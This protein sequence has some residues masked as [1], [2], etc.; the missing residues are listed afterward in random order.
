MYRDKSVGL[1]SRHA[2]ETRG[3]YSLAVH[4]VGRIARGERPGHAAGRLR[5][6]IRL[7][8]TRRPRLTYLSRRLSGLSHLPSSGSVSPTIESTL[9]ACHLILARFELLHSPAPQR[10]GFNCSEDHSLQKEADQNH[11][12]GFG[13]RRPA[14]GGPGRSSGPPSAAFHSQIEN[15]CGC[16]A[17][18]QRP[19]YRV[20][21]HGHEAENGPKIILAPA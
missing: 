8:R 5:G 12:Q 9:F 17:E 16:C 15:R 13:S 21:D 4:A 6:R 20:D 14:R 2:A 11:A 1:Q 18:G 10:S 7:Q 3:G 19:Q